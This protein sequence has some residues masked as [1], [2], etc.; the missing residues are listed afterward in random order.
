[1]RFLLIDRVILVDGLYVYNMHNIVE[2]HFRISISPV[3]S[4]GGSLVDKY[5]YDTTKYIFL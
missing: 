5:D 2:K 4:Q 1:M 3:R